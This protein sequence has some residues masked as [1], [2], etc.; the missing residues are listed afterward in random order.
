MLVVAAGPVHWLIRL[1]VPRGLSGSSPRGRE[2]SS[3]IRYSERGRASSSA[4]APPAT[5]HGRQS[6][7]VNRMSRVASRRQGSKR[8]FR[9]IPVVDDGATHRVRV[10]LG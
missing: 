10:V 4:H 8:R 6:R 5:D 9:A 7:S 3:L 2:V 1:D